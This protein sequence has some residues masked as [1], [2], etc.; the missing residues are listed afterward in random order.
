MANIVRTKRDGTITIS[1]NAGAN[2]VVVAFEAGDLVINVPGV[3]VNNY[4]DRGQITDPPSLR[5]GDDQPMTGSFS[6]NARD[7]ETSTADLSDLVLSSSPSGWVSTL[8]VNAEVDTF[9]LVFA[10]EGSDHGETDET[11]TCNYCLFTG[12]YQEGDPNTLSFNFIAFDVYPT[13][14]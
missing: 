2:S 9:T 14:A 8:G 1:D 6:A 4:L 5:L 3:A 13:V 7:V 12:A 10:I 11:I